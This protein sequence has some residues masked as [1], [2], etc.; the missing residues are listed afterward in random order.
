M[1][2]WAIL[3]VTLGL[4]GC[5]VAA[6]IVIP[7]VEYVASVNNLGAETLKFVDDKKACTKEKPNG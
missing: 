6:E 1:I 4:S 7:F 2:R 5:G 3:L